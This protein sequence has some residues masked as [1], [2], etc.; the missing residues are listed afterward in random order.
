M[1]CGFGI[2]CDCTYS[3]LKS[4]LLHLGTL[5]MPLRQQQLSSVTTGMIS[6]TLLPMTLLSHP[7]L[8]TGCSFTGTKKFSFSD[9]V[10]KTRLKK[11]RLVCPR[12]LERSEEDLPMM[13]TAPRLTGTSRLPTGAGSAI[14]QAT[15]PG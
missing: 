3:I 10:G 4:R 9:N 7:F 2:G 8:E 14:L 11:Q 15:P 5:M 6:A 13:P 12:Q 1:P